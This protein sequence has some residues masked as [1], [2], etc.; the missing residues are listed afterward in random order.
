LGTIEEKTGDGDEAEKLKHKAKETRQ[1]IGRKDED[2]DADE[3]YSKLVG[4]MLW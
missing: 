2:K 1:R 4:Y 3:T